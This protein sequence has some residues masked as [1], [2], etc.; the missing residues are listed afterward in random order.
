MAS[1][2]FLGSINQKQKKM[3][4]NKS[5]RAEICALRHMN[6]AAEIWAKASK[7]QFVFEYGVPSDDYEARV[8]E[9]WAMVARHNEHQRMAEYWASKM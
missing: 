5:N 3:T 2:P 9:F 8:V 4:R 6:V 7:M 1:C